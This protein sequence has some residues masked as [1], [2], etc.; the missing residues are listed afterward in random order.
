MVC[1]LACKYTIHY[2]ETS[3]TSVVAFAFG[4][5]IPRGVPGLLSW[6]HVLLSDIFHE[7]E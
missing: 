1:L 7:C 5:S 2:F 6:R 3:L 4:W